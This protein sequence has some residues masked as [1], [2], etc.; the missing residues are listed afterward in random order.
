MSSVPAVGEEAPGFTLNDQAGRGVRL[1]DLR[2]KWV[3]LYFYPKDG[4]PG[5]TKEACNLRDNHAAIQKA[6]AV[7]LGVSADTAASHAKFAEKYEL[8]FQLLVDDGDHPV[9][10]AY[11]AYGL[12]KNYGKTYEGVIRSTVVIDPAGRVAKVWPRVKPAAHGD[13]VLAWLLK[14]A[15]TATT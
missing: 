9:A 11:G 14:L 10:R 8:P 6:G 12:K 4:T 5:C 15:E 13:E 2:G 1:A 7:I 3:V